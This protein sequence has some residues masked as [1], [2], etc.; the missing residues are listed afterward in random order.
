MV[1]NNIINFLSKYYKICV[2]GD[3]YN[4]IHVT[5]FGFVNKKKIYDLLSKSKAALTSEENFFSLFIIDAINSNLKII[6]F[7]K[8]FNNPYLKKYF[9]FINKSENFLI[10]KKIVNKIL[11]LNFKYDN[12]F[13]KKIYM[14]Q[15]KIDNFI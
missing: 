15:K 14:Q 6:S 9:F 2:V 10:I 12:N 5:N 4:N 8:T 3:F 7:N 1:R 13:K 11:G